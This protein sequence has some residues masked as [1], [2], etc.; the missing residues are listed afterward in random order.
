MQSKSG[1]RIRLFAVGVGALLQLYLQ[2]AAADTLSWIPLG[3][4]PNTKGQVENI[5]DKEVE[6]AVEAIALDPLDSQVAYVGT[7]NG[8][9]WK[10]SNAMAANPSWTLMSGP[11]SSGSIGA[12][13][14]DP[15]DAGRKLVVAGFGHSSSYYGI[16]GEL[17]GIVRSSD[18][19]EH[20][21]EPAGDQLLQGLNVVGIASRG[22]TI[23]VATRE[24]GIYQSRDSGIS[25]HLVSSDPRAGL[26]PGGSHCLAGDPGDHERLYA[27]VGSA[28][29]YV[30]H[31]TGASWRKISDGSL[32]LL[33]GI[34]ADNVKIAVGPSHALYVAIAANG[35][36]SG[37][38]RSTN[39]GAV[40]QRLDVPV[41]SED[42][43]PIGINPG[44]QAAIHL[45]LA[46]DPKNPA[47]AYVGGDR[48]PSRSEGLPGNPGWPNSI[49]A[50]DYTG[51][52]FRVD[53]SR[54]QNQQA[55]PITNSGTTNNSAPH[56]DSR[57]I[58]FTA[59]D[60]LV[61]ADDG[62]VYR[63]SS[64]QSAGGQWFSMNG[65]LEVTELHSV[66][67]DP[68][69][70]I[71]IG[72]A[73]DTGTPEQRPSKD[74]R[75]QSVSTGDGGSVAVDRGS[76]AGRSVRY[77]S[78]YDLYNFR[79]EVYGSANQ[80]LS[81]DYPPLSPLD[82][83]PPITPQFYTPIAT[84]AVVS[85]RLI[86][87]GK[88]SVYESR[89]AGDTVREIGPG[90]TINEP[91][92]IGYGTVTDPDTVYVGAGSSLY[93]RKGQY[94]APLARLSQ[95]PGTTNV[96]DIA[97]DASRD[98]T[99]FVAGV[100]ELFGTTDAGITWTNLLGNLLTLRP[101]RIISIALVKISSQQALAV[102]TDTGVFA[103][104]GPGYSH[105]NRFGQGL[106]DVGVYHLDYSPQDGVLVAGTLGRGAW[107]LPL[108][109]GARALLL[110][111]TSTD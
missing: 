22:N 108:S 85:G 99:V 103:A 100:S 80:L 106:P 50:T 97:L 87:G 105:W 74:V 51:R 1:W 65:N 32:D 19:G 93:V 54:P 47:L 102:G 63:R 79:R 23:I 41:T 45:S 86:I 53:A 30:S 104:T 62:G 29:I 40:W 84:N 96:M 94:P 20:W 81:I 4:S 69:S 70:H 57:A 73:Q 7:V 15:T 61:E 68:I 89:D 110:A 75:W 95:Y 55:S 88:N 12:I 9:I 52:L 6:G 83:A 38:F 27:D 91:A 77:S 109:A 43:G 34:P 18:G 13:E 37:F 14:I 58:A 16:G 21:N 78:Y 49:G 111:S 39:D 44:Q 5:A 28:G 92:P 66:A 36:L 2:L 42:A 82:G 17:D 72:G 3:P 48:Q 107:A 60:T 26:P 24:R 71:A 25:F 67:W 46:A 11:A 64:P 101:G 33:L 31:N 56:A 10:T 90:I 98:G 59:N 8:G 76:V 35:R